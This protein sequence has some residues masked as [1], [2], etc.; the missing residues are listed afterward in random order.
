MPLLNTRIFALMAMLYGLT[1]AVQATEFALVP[2]SAAKTDQAPAPWRVVGV[3]G[4]KIPLT[5]FSVVDVDGRKVVRVEASKSYGN[6]VHD[7]PLKAT[8]AGLRLNWQWRLDEPI[9]GAD[10]HSREG[11]DSP[12]KVCVLFD[13][14]LEKLGL[15]NRN[16]LRFARAASAEKLPSATLCYVWD[17]KLSP[18]TLLPNA[19]TDRVR[20][21][22]ATGSAKQL[23]QW[24]EVS[25]DV[26]ADFQRAFG[27]ESDTLPP[28]MAVLVGG[29][30]DNT[31][32]HSLGYVDSLRLEP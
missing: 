29:D 9:Q 6:L 15:I 13:M 4:G 27:T 14:P 12:L 18:E 16:L 25:R 17:D 26:A 1:F 22:V 28:V 20:I 8:V 23:G 5:R 11:D 32:G 7:L 2:F 24:V 21:I 10:L 19:Y 30:A 3:P 31:G